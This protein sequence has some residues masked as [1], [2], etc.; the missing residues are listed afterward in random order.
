[1]YKNL[2]LKTAQPCKRIVDS[3]NVK[4]HILTSNYQIYLKNY[5]ILQL[6]AHKMKK[7]AYIY[8]FM[9]NFLKKKTFFNSEH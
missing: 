4:L 7:M 2:H 6:Y 9:V 1:M 3:H 5:C 8:I